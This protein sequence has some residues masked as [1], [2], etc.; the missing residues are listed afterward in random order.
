MKLSARLGYLRERFTPPFLYRYALPAWYK[1]ATGRTID[2]KYPKTFSDK[3]NWIKLYG[4][5]GEMTRLSDKL[6][7]RD[8]IREKLGEEYLVPLIGAWDNFFD[9]DFS[10]LPDRFVLKANHGS[11]MNIVVKDKST[12]D[13]RAAQ[14]TAQEW[15]KTNFAYMFGFQMQY[16]DIVPKLIIEEY[17]ESDS[18]SEEPGPPPGISAGELTDYKIH[19]FNGIPESIE[20]ISGEGEKRRLTFLNL[21]WEP[22]WYRTATYPVH[23]T[24]PPRPE[25]L[26][27]LI[28]TAEVLSNGFPYVRVDLYVVKGQV[29]FGEMTFTPSSGQARWVPEEAERYLGGLI[30][31]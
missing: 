7:V 21:N 9:I 4:V 3:I 6:L 24:C 10:S 25:K 22:L 11:H 13:L 20:Y 27:D 15:L 28:R 19:C 29:K 23:E 16:K 26:S 18:D 12:L 2:L 8:W 17:M 1:R 30:T 14:L 5:T 31:L